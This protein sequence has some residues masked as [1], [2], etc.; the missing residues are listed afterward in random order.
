MLGAF[1]DKEPEP[2]S[3]D[4]PQTPDGDIELE[5]ADTGADDDSYE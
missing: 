2:S 1:F 4:A 3:G 5:T